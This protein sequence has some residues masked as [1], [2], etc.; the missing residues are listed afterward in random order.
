MKNKNEI[1]KIADILLSVGSKDN[2]GKK[3]DTAYNDFDAD[4]I[5]K[6]GCD[7]LNCATALVLEGYEKKTEGV[8]EEHVDCIHGSKFVC[9]VCKEGIRHY[10]GQ[11]YCDVCGSK[12]REEFES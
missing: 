5:F 9:S 4:I 2:R 10:Y 12:M 3:I 1:L 11:K 8:W 6:Y 7:R